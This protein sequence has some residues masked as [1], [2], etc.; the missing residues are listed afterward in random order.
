[1]ATC[2]ELSVL[3]AQVM[4]DPLL[5]ANHSA[6]HN[7][8]YIDNLMRAIAISWLVEVACE[9]GFHQETLHTAAALLDRFLSSSK[10]FS[11]YFRLSISAVALKALS[12]V[13]SSAM[14]YRCSRRYSIS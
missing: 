8:M 3:E 1:M 5:L 4:P 11:A 14:H 13:F 7:E 12:K 10:V 2:R 6:A 9:Y